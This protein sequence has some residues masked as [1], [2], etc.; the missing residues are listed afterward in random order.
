MTLFPVRGHRL[1]NANRSR[2]R[3][4]AAIKVAVPSDSKRAR[5]AEDTGSSS[6]TSSTTDANTSS[7]GTPRATSVAT[8]RSEPGDTGTA[9]RVRDRRWHQLGEVG[10]AHFGVG[11][12]RLTQTGVGSHQPPQA[13][14][15]NNRGPDAR[16]GSLQAT[17]G[18]TASNRRR[19]ASWKVMTPVARTTGAP[20][21]RE[22][23][24]S[25]GRDD[26]LEGYWTLR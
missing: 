16:T 7:G 3:P 12:Q 22:D 6:A 15:D 8:R 11:R 19:P 14:L 18:R 24:A 2:I 21:G 13:A 10:Q 20:A 9:L 25:R 5:L 17:S 1:P 4:N 23:T 26:R